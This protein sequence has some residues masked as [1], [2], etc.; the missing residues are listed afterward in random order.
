MNK[1]ILM[2][3]LTKDPEIRVSQSQTHIARFS[4][5]VDR[6]FKD[7][8]GN[9]ET[10]FFNCTAFGKLAEF[11]E[12]YLKKGIKVIV[13]GRLQNDSFTNREGQ[14]VTVTGIVLDEIEFCEKKPA[15]PTPEEKTEWAAIVSMDQEE[16]PFNFYEGDMEYIDIVFLTDENHEPCLAVAPAFSHLTADDRVIIISPDNESHVCKV[17]RSIPEEKDG[18]DYKF[19]ALIWGEDPARLKVTKQITYTDLCWDDP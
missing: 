3:R 14:K 1:V 18:E 17:V 7:K 8:D 4:I 6:R 19:M 10:D 11:A 9:Q 15:E 16:L 13:S 2:G 12:K 5:A